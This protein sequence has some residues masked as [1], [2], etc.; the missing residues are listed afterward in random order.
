MS[1]RKWKGTTASITMIVNVVISVSTMTV[2]LVIATIAI[3]KNIFVTS[4]CSSRR[5]A[6]LITAFLSAL[7]T[8]SLQIDLRG[9]ML[10]AVKQS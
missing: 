6:L 2:I 1:L 4:S 7:F 10:R 9:R 5:L 3:T 8:S